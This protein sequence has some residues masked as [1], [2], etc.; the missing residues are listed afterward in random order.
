MKQTNF[1]ATARKFVMGLVMLLGFMLVSGNASAQSFAS[2][3]ASF[4]KPATFK[5]P[6]VAKFDLKAKVEDLKANQTPN[7]DLESIMKSN[8][9]VAALA[10]LELGTDTVQA[11][12]DGLAKVAQV[13]NHYLEA[14][15]ASLEGVN[16]EGAV[17]NA[18]Q[19]LKK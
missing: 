9:W 18:R 4:S 8:Y 19:L 2:N 3:T 10:S 13:Y 6:A 1:G 12:K 17:Q 14:D 7:P 11:D 16:V 15:P 5:E